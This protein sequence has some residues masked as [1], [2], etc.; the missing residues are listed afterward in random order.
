VVLLS[1]LLAGCQ[2][3]GPR[4]TNPDLEGDGRR[5]RS[6]MA[7]GSLEAAFRGVTTVGF[8][9]RMAIDPRATARE[10]LTERERLGEAIAEQIEGL[11]TEAGYEWLDE[12]RPQ[13]TI[14]FAW[15]LS[16][17]DGLPELDEMSRI[18]PGIPDVGSLQRGMLVVAVSWPGRAAPVCRVSIDGVGRLDQP[19][20]TKLGA[21]QDSLVRLL[22]GVPRG[23]VALAA[24]P[25][26]DLGPKTSPKTVGG[27]SGP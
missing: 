11:F 6:V 23:P 21:I 18:A 13:R 26:A 15:F 1:V 16:E 20:P 17:S 27:P 8:A 2:S 14:E 9:E 7:A 10:T 4:G 12:G 22:T 3:P 5:L 25:E 24:E 19:L